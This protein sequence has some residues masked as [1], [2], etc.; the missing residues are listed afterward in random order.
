MIVDQVHVVGVR[1]LEAEHDPP[2]ARDAYRPVARAVA[3]Q[4]MQPKTG[5]IHMRGFGR[6][7]QAGEDALD[8]GDRFRR[9]P[10]PVSILVQKP[11]PLVA[12][13]PDH[14]FTRDPAICNL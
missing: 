14:R 5:Q 3:L 12:K 2:I 11:E 10:P 4:R 1:A 8:P 6:F 9:H 13:I 7:V